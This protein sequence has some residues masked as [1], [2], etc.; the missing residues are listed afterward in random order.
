M[1]SN[2]SIS[3]KTKK[4]YS[5]GMDLFKGILI[6]VGITIHILNND[7]RNNFIS[8]L[9][10]SFVMPLFLSVSGYLLN[11]KFIET[12]DISTFLKKYFKKL[13]LPS[14]FAISVFFVLDLILAWRIFSLK[15]LLYMIIFPSYH[16]WYI[17]TLFIFVLIL[18]GLK[19]LKVKNIPML[20]GSI[21]FSYILAYYTE[22][23]YDWSIEILDLFF[24]KYKFPY[25]SFFI[26]GYVISH[27]D[28]KKRSTVKRIS[29]GVAIFTFVGRST[30]FLLAQGADNLTS[31]DFYILNFALT[32][33]LIPTFET[34]NFT[35]KIEKFEKFE[36]QNPIAS[37]NHESLQNDQLKSPVESEEWN[38]KGQ[39]FRLL[40]WV[41]KNSLYV[42][43]W[44]P[45]F[46]YL[47]Y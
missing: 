33:W 28:L 38:K 39:F 25:F 13:L 42:Y 44:H 15:N 16:F 5:H 17:N 18:W 8:Y 27:W 46:Q 29:A 14:F 22:N 23:V 3:Q 24:L 19:Q 45:I 2:A 43:L 4:K 32:L 9:L 40:F 26:F 12:T 30:F 31:F 10:Y 34:M 11:H 20:I 41:G 35:T 1:D 21:I 47:I 36:V 37:I 6:I 7:W